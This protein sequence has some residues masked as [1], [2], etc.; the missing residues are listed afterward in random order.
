VET[1]PEENG[2]LD[3]FARLFFGVIAVITV[4]LALLG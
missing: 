4:I 3:T 2:C 1:P